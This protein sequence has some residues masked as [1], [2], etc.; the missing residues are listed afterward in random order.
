MNRHVLTG[1]HVTLQHASKLMVKWENL[2]IQLGAWKS[3][4]RRRHS[5]RQTNRIHTLSSCRTAHTTSCFK[6]LSYLLTLT[7][8]ILSSPFL[9]HTVT[10]FFCISACLSWFYFLALLCFTIFV[11]LLLWLQQFLSLKSV[12]AKLIDAN[13]DTLKFTF[14]S[15]YIL[16]QITLKISKA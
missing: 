11:L 6:I 1:V 16:N 10:I 4:F 5:L 7:S 9:C 2:P 12:S 14:L 3:C 15:R 13:K 8:I